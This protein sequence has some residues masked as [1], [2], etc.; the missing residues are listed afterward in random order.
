MNSL[1]PYFPVFKFVA[2]FAGLYLMLSFLYGIYLQRDYSA[3][4]YPDPVTAAVAHQVSGIVNLLGRTS[5]TLNSIEHPSVKLFLGSKVVY[6]VIEGCNAVSV[7]I[8]FTSF[9]LAFAKAWKS[10]IIY[11]LIGI[12]TIYIMNLVR[13]VLLA[14]IYAD[15]YDY[16]HISHEIFFPSIIYGTVILLWLYW[17]KSPKRS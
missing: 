5:A 7:M 4:F 2:V 3:S 13:L 12:V 8:L 6:R 16:A 17:I 9:V 15:Y 1:R 11:L 14:Y 10:T